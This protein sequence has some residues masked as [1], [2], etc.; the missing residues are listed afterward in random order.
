MVAIYSQICLLSLTLERAHFGKLHDQ[1]RGDLSLPFKNT[2]LKQ[3]NH[4]CQYRF[5]EIHI[6]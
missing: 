4:R 5:I 2:T 3:E 6:K 1:A